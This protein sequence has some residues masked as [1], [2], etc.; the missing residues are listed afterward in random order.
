[1]LGALPLA[2]LSPVS[3]LPESS[4]G[5]A[6]VTRAR[7]EVTVPRAAALERAPLRVVVHAHDPEALVV[8]AAPLE[9]VHQR[10]REVAAD[11]HAVG[12][13]AGHGLDV[14]V[15]VRDAV[16]VVDQPVAGGRI[17]E[18]RPVLG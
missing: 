15:E 5:A 11:V 12:D 3:A 16:G 8:A 2:N 4:I 7:D 14:A 9:V 6:R 10:P 18:G 13:R 1:M 17:V